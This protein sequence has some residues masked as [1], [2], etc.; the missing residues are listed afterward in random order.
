MTWMEHSFLAQKE[1]PITLINELLVQSNI[2][3]SIRIRENER[4][5]ACK[6][7]GSEY[8]AAE[9]S[10][11]E[12]NALLIAADVLAAPSG[13]LLLIDEPERHLHRSI[14]SPLL[15]QLFRRRADCGFVISTHDQDLPLEIPGARVL[16]LRACYFDGQNVRSWDT[17]ELPPD[18][19]SDD[20]LKRE[21]LG[22]RR[23][24][25]FVE[26]TDHSLDKSL[27]SLIFPSVTVIPRG[28]GQDVERAVVG[29]RAGEGLHWLSA[30]GIAD[31]DG[32]ESDY[33]QAKLAIGVYLI[34]FYSVEAV[35]YHPKI[36]ERVAIRVSQEVSGDESRALIRRALEGS[37]AAIS[38]HTERLAR[39][40]T[41]KAARKL[42]V[43]QLP[44]D[45]DLLKGDP[46]VLINQSESILSNRK[47]ELD[48]AVTNG[49]WETI[50]IKA[51]VRES[52]ALAGIADCL[53]FQKMDDYEKAVRHILSTDEEA[54]RFAR[55]LFGGLFEQLRD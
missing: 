4:V 28:S 22:A 43:E 9:L 14:I 55:G 25:L 1:A 15:G 16:L 21:L 37:V 47:S 46:V 41:K 40:A 18:A 49:D 5:V 7:G 33:I 50:L 35:Y 32:Y 31:G 34:P 8:G 20:S 27:Y 11:G 19:L 26:G 10:D 29:L 44:N 53:G 13:T 24:V 30:F 17:D 39:K 54:L 51:P 6:D 42:I 45:E 48:V 2:P 3:I 12:R 23:K 52:N 38:K 36:I